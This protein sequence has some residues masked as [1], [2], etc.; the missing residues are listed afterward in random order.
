[1]GKEAIHYL[2]GTSATRTEIRR[3]L[4]AEELT[5]PS[6]L[7]PRPQ[8]RDF[9][10]WQPIMARRKDEYK[11]LLQI[12]ET[13]HIE[14]AT[15]D[16]ILLVPIGDVHAE[17][18][19]TNL[20]I[21]GRD[22]DLAKSVNAYFLTFGDLTNS[23]FWKQE[24]ALVSGEEA[25]MYMRSA[26]KYMAE[27]NHLL[28]GW[29]GDHDGWAYDKHGTHT[30]YADFWEKFNAHLLDGVSYVDITLNNGEA[31]QK[32]AII[33]SHQHKGF[34]IYNDAHAAWRQQLDEANTSRDIISI[35]AH[36]HTKAYLQ[37][38]R[39]CFGG[40][41]KRIHAI[42]L[43]TCKE[44][45]RYSRK[46]GW[47]RKGEETASAFGIVL[48]PNKDRVEIHWNLE[49]AVESMANQFPS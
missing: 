11:E 9:T 34:S 33:G 40:D 30:L 8:Q 38:T 14:I 24:P 18:P 17:H 37:Q 1:M 29:L 20:G 2:D 49:E 45:D 25:T 4:L 19:E 23:I 42:S 13:I 46:H 15:K 6:H 22:I 12:P 26:I 39:K 21:F 32:Y 36:K 28:C 35:T 41:E 31:E 44:T 43:G 5:M 47:P 3:K 16:P 7:T 27:D 10:E 48:H